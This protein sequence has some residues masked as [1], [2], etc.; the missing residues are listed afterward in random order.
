MLARAFDV[1]VPVSPYPQHH[2]SKRDSS[3]DDVQHTVPNIR[4]V[5]SSLASVP[6]SDP[7]S[8]IPRIET[9][10]EF[11]RTPIELAKAHSRGSFFP[12]RSIRGG[13][14]PSGGIAGFSCDA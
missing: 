7:A 5:L 13:A 1:S 11:T 8:S 3:L 12:F 14:I 2:A 10:F 4:G 6:Y 9:C